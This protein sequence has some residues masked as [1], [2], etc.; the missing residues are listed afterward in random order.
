MCSHRKLYYATWI[1]I[2]DVLHVDITW[3]LLLIAILWWLPMSTRDQ[4][5]INLWSTATTCSGCFVSLGS[6]FLTRFICWRNFSIG[7]EGTRNIETNE[8]TL[9]KQLQ[10]YTITRLCVSSYN[11]VYLKCY[12]YYWAIFMHCFSQGMCLQECTVAIPYDCS[13]YQIAYCRCC[14]SN[15]YFLF[16]HCNASHIEWMYNL[17][18][19][20]I[21]RVT[22]QVWFVCFEHVS[23][24]AWPIVYQQHMALLC[25]LVWPS[26]FKML[27]YNI[28]Y[29]IR[30]YVICGTQVLLT[31]HT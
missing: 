21:T 19:L 13:E 25:L 30:S 10:V 16:S 5:M 18:T 12:W 8:K 11:M 17:I 28:H 27:L 9:T 15:A 6:S 24:S 4:R 1:V 7:K 31:S 22:A 3:V 26:L 29:H 20:W 14:W 23:V 2:T